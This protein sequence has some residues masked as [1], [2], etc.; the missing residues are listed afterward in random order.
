M[1]KIYI[2][3]YHNVYQNIAI[4]RYLFEHA[5]DDIILYLWSNSPCVVCGRNQNIYN[6]VNIEYASSH[7]IDIIRRFSGGGAVYQDLGNLDYT[8]I[9]KEDYSLDELNKLILEVF[10]SLSL[11]VC[12]SGRNDLII[13]NRKFSGIAYCND[14]SHIMY[15]GTCL[16]DTSLEELVNVLKPHDYKLKSHSVASYKSRVI[17]LKALMT[18]SFLI[19]LISFK[20]ITRDL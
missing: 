10:K 8:F 9:V 18:S 1:I 17:N 16:I 13:D 20:L 2:S 4:E 14:F 15:H 3:P 5:S 11:D 19:S 12:F 6:E 7:K